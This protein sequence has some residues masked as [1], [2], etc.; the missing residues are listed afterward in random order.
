MHSQ[1]VLI[2]NPKT[3]YPALTE[4]VR[5][6]VAGYLDSRNWVMVSYNVQRDLLQQAL[7]IAPGKR[8][9]SIMA[10]EDTGWVAVQLLTNKLTAP[11]VMDELSD[12][13]AKDIIL[14]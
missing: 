9:P 3:A 5:K 7:R 14:T 1:A 8:S 4:V 10:L 12:L 2:G 13:G 11:R 6:R